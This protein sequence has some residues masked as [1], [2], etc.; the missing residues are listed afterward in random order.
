[1]HN[2]DNMYKIQKFQKHKLPNIFHLLQNILINSAYLY[3]LILYNWEKTELDFH[4]KQ[5]NAFW[6]EKKNYFHAEK[7]ST[8]TN[9][10]AIGST[11]NFLAAQIIISYLKNNFFAG[12]LLSRNAALKIWYLKILF[13]NTT[14]PKS[15]VAAASCKSLKKMN[16]PYRKNPICT[17]LA[18]KQ[19]QQRNFILLADRWFY[20]SEKQVLCKWTFSI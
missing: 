16:D 14:I 5:A 10:T 7:N 18:A 3:V 1:M 11:F 13:K 20:F 8:T 2:T 12:N 6:I 9:R 19:Q 4:A 15:R 17:K